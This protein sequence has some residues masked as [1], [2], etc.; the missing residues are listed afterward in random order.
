MPVSRIEIHHVGI[1]INSAQR[2]AQDEI[3]MP[4]R[5]RR[6]GHV[7]KVART[8]CRRTRLTMLHAMVTHQKPWHVP[9]VPSAYHTSPLDK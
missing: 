8:A 4:P 9:E 7:A 1:G 2:I 3:D 5:K 6:A